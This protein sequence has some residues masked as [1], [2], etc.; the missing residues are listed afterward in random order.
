MSSVLLSVPALAG[1]R[2]TARAA[3]PLSWRDLAGR[4][5]GSADLSASSATAFIFGSTT[6]PCADGYNKRIAE[7]ARDYK[8]RGVRVFLVFSAPGVDQSAVSR[9]VAS[10]RVA[11]PSVYDTGGRLAKRL[12]AK[13]SPTAVVLDSRGQV[14]YRGRID[15]NPDAQA[16]VRQDLREALND[17]LANS[18]VRLAKTS[19]VGCNLAGKADGKG[20]GG[21]PKLVEG[22]GT[23]AFPVTTRSTNAQKYFNQGINRW[24][25]FNFPE[26]EASFKEAARLDPQCAMAHWGV[27]LSLGM[28]YNM[29]FDPSRLPEATAA[30]Q[31]AS[32]LAGRASARERALIQALAIRHAP[33]TEMAKQLDAYHTAMS[34][35]FLEYPEDVN[36]AVLYAASGMD[37][38]PWKLW[39]TAGAPEPGTMEVLLT[40]EDAMRR[41]PNHIGVNHYYIHATEASPFPERALKCTGRLAAQAP[42]SGHL[43]HMPSHTYLR[44]G[45]YRGSIQANVRAAEVDAAYYA[46]KGTPTAYGGYYIHNLDF[47]VASMLFEGRAKESVQAARELST[48]AAKWTPDFASLFCGSGSSIMTVYARFGM[49]DEILKAPAADESNPFSAIPWR[50]ARGMALTARKDP[51]GAAKELAALEAQ[52]PAGEKAA[53]GVPIPGFT[54]GLKHAWRT[55]RLHLA[56]KIAAA[57]GATE[58][59][60]NRYRQAIEHEDAI[61]YVE[62]PL[63][64]HPVRES[65]GALLLTQGKAGEAEQVFRDALKVHRRSGRA[66]FG[67][68][69]ALERQGKRVEATKV[70]AEFT[71]AWKRADVKLS[72]ADL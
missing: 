40:L 18:P 58:E 61:P 70:R 55:A 20:G 38:R 30:A 69:E 26:A 67:L 5:Y 64:R 23:V 54:E 25:G 7:V 72:L 57:R 66:L 49:W 12:G 34:R 10:R 41:D 44:V 3:S 17:L 6:C 11:V 24:F 2:A 43:V 28:N 51:A 9:Y 35:V 53:E 48:V 50:Y 37:L 16:V 59:A 27:A 63:W 13:T 32:E 45:D 62:P 29:D 39:T 19:V 1:T 21:R 36:V 14:K 60:A 15:D 56:G 65:L 52:L 31:K 4:T 46:E 68:T 33:G 47:I 22:I 71:E 8:S 42:S